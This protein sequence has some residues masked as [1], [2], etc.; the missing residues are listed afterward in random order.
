MERGYPDSSQKPG[1]AGSPW[2]EGRHGQ[3]E[4]HNAS[5]WEGWDA[6]NAGYRS[7]GVTASRRFAV[8][9]MDC[10]PTP[11][12]AWN[13][14]RARATPQV[15]ETSKH[16]LWQDHQNQFGP[17]AFGMTVFERA[18]L[19]RLKLGQAL[20]FCSFESS[21]AGAEIRRLRP[22]R[23]PGHPLVDGGV[24]ALE[25][26]TMTLV[27]GHDGMRWSCDALPTFSDR[28]RHHGKPS[29]CSRT[30]IHPPG[31]DQSHGNTSLPVRRAVRAESHCMTCR[32]MAW[33]E[34]SGGTSVLI[35]T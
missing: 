8:P 5:K 15:L 32:A 27:V 22:S 4:T 1:K 26:R 2:F 7:A 33:L 18:G 21:G 12:S 35:S 10:Q 16:G 9:Q 11:K 31:S 29:L 14:A 25:C 19:S 28:L 23:F 20:S 6:S 3:A 17:Q 30:R 13:P 34:A 24:A